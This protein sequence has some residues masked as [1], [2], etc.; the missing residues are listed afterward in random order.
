MIFPILLSFIISSVIGYCVV[1]LIWP[2]RRSGA[3]DLIVRCS[4]AAG[5]GQGIASCN[6]FLWLVVFGSPGRGSIVVEV[7]L[8]AILLLVLVYRVKRKRGSPPE[9]E[10]DPGVA[11]EGTSLKLKHGWLLTAAFYTSLVSTVA[12]IV[13]AS[14]RFPNGWWDA[15]AIWNLRA[16]GI[17]RGGEH[18]RDSLSDLTLWAHPN[19]PLLL[20]TSVARGWVY[21][22]AETAAVPAALSLLFTIGTVAL[23]CSALAELRSKWQ[24]YV[25]GVVLLGYTTFTFYGGSQIADPPLMFLFT[26]TVI[27]VAFKFERVGGGYGALVLAGVTA[28]LSAWTKNEGLLFIVLVAVVQLIVVLPSE[29]ARAYL[30]QL[31]FFAAGLLPV[32]IIVLYFKTQ[33]APPSELVS[34]M[35]QRD[36]FSKLLDYHRYI[37]IARKLKEDVVSYNVYGIGFIYLLL[38]YLVCVGATLRHKRSVIFTALLLHLMLTGYVWVYLTTPYDLAW[39]LDTSFSRLTLHL[40]P[41]FVFL[42]FLLVLTPEETLRR[43]EA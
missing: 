39:H 13:I 34:A 21:T 38:I 17:L 43:K 42:F 5:V 11:S 3:S 25:A 22:G 7:V 10:R 18:W 20:P 28:G 23:L 35:Q 40:W 4:L 12:G 19:Y 33:L 31:L 15:W 1:S 8:L 36:T 32:L 27:L 9:A 24:G 37:L 26:A 29:G 41:S 14:L 6:F 30:R 16:R 2:S